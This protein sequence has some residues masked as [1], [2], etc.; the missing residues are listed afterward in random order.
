MCF[1]CVVV[2]VF[3]YDVLIVVVV[4]LWLLCDVLCVLC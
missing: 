2:D 1:F 4:L 3:V